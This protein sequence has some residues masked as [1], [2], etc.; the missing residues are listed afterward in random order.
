MPAMT[1]DETDGYLELEFTHKGS[2]PVTVN[3]DIFEANN[4]YAALTAEHP[5]LVE[6]GAAWV[7]WLMDKGAP[8]LSHG[9]AFAVAT[10][11]MDLADEF[12]KKKLGYASESADSPASTGSPSST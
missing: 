12:A 2:E 3:L 10:K 8:R 5:D 1:I 6:Q 7:T 9:A 11:L 4:V